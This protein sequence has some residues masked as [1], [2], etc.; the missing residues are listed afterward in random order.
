[1]GM[2]KESSGLRIDKK[3]PPTWYSI[4]KIQSVVSEQSNGAKVV[5]KGHYWLPGKRSQVASHTG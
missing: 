1:M 4:P 2:G 3:I 5:V